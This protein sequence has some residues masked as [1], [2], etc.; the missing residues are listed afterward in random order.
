[1][2][3]CTSSVADV[4]TSRRSELRHWEERLLAN[5][6]DLEALVRAAGISLDLRQSKKAAEYARRAA[7]LQAA[8]PIAH[9]FLGCALC[10]EGDWR[11]AQMA[12][13]RAQSLDPKNGA[14]VVRLAL[15]QAR[16]GRAAEA[17]KLAEE[18][19]RFPSLT[20][21]SLIL[22]ADGLRELSALDQARQV[23]DRAQALGET[24]ETCGALGRLLLDQR[25]YGDALAMLQRG[26][27]LDSM[28]PGI[29][30]NLGWTWLLMGDAERGV[31]LVE[32][33]VELDPLDRA[34]VSRAIFHLNADP[35]I[36]LA[37]AHRKTTAWMDRTYPLAPPTCSPDH[38]RD[39][40]R[41]LRI[42]Y[43]SCDFR[44]H[45]MAHWIGPLLEH[46]DRQSFE[47]IAFAG[48]AME[49]D[50]T[51]RYKALADRWVRTSE[52]SAE[53]MA[54]RVRDL[55]VDILVDLSGHTVGHRLDV[56]ALKPA[57]VQVCYLGFDRSTGLRAMD[58]RIVHPLSDPPGEADACS[59]ERLWRLEGRFAFEPSPNAPEI[60]PLPAAARGH[61]TFGFLGNHARI[62]A[63]FMD[64]A[65]ELLKAIP[66]SELVLLCLDG[67]DEVH[68]T[69]KRERLIHAGVAPERLRFLSRRPSEAEFLRYY[70]EVDITLN[71]FPAE[72]G[73]TLCESLW[74][75]VPVLV[76]D[77][78][79]ALR[80]TGASILHD[81]GMTDWV[82]T[83]LDD[84][85]S[86]AQK[87][88]ADREGLASLRATLRERMAKSPVCDGHSSL[89]AIEAAYR[90]MWR[91]WCEK[92]P[93]GG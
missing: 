73:T 75:G 28:H 30:A 52:L 86:I 35:E 70:H 62:G 7:H 84:W 45:A 26:L 80:H 25:A 8:L 46:R 42:G 24:A 66:G 9:F 19:L 27:A 38:D 15:V 43:V 83:N 53:A 41:R 5:P 48:S 18:A 33:A 85:K 91:D 16:Q 57:P 74:M 50:C 82:A 31:P 54:Q 89:R 88:N 37:E 3:E 71:S 76:Y 2:A 17:I 47:V 69:F 36:T 21:E 59:T 61:L 81:M 12:L 63:S 78:P 87:W 22:L 56:F 34:A 4:A 79:Q 29:T 39:P 20:Q 40:E 68:Q 32:R 1:M 65:A 58:W 11:G 44:T 51:R 67:Q 49:D 72:G 55:K 23:L 13:T 93:S 60:N 77:R 90:G 92:A 14:P 6:K 10:E 64:A